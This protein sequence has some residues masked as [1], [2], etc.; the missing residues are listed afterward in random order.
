MEQMMI[1]ALT[2]DI[3][4][5]FQVHNL[6]AVVSRDDW[7]GYES[8]VALG[9][10]RILNV[11][12]EAEVKATF[13]IL[14]WI[15]EHHPDLV[16]R[17]HA[18]GHE[19]A[20]HGYGHHLVYRQT[21]DQFREDLRRS[22]E[23]TEALTGE[24]ILGYRAPSFSI[25]QE[26]VWALDILRELG[27]RYDTSIYPA[28]PLVHSRYGWPEAPKAPYQI[29]EG[30][31]EFPMTVVRWLGRDF[32]I[33]G[34]GWFRHYPY[35]VTRAGLRQVNRAGRPAMVYVHPWEVDP[36]QPHLN[37]SRYKGYLHYHNLHKTEGRLRKLVRDFRF[38]PI[39]EVLGLEN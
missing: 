15:A 23:I 2:I 34:G 35:W 8:R 6:E 7:A 12:A 4:E 20:A 17:I 32:P 36:G 25:I 16:K 37:T 33:G 28:R 5:Y 9:T 22:L 39:R 30:L 13:F 14:G 26:S 24:K 21:P 11:L 31:W 19:I 27:L 1:N 10:G 18:Q 38:A 3:E 29:R